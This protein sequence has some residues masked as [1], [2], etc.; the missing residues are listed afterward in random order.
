MLE[1]FLEHV[2]ER[3]VTHLARACAYLRPPGS[4]LYV[5]KMRSAPASV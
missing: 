1:N 3:K 4:V 5:F 2:P